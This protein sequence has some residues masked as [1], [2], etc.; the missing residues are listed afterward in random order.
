MF[1][2]SYFVLFNI[3]IIHRCILNYRI[4]IKIEPLISLLN[5]LY[6]QIINASFL[7]FEHRTM[8]QSMI[9]STDKKRIKN[10]HK[11]VQNTYVCIYILINPS[12]KSLISFPS[13]YFIFPLRSIHVLKLSSL[14]FPYNFP[15]CIASASKY[16]N[17]F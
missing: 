11:R 13:V 5:S 9:Y 10:N 12:S 17:S 4:K 14:K 2:T 8:K 16:A 7:K 1:Q 3:H 15:Y 6:I